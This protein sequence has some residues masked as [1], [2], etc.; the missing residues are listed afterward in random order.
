MF[1][2]KKTNKQATIVFIFHR[3]HRSTTK[4][5]GE[6]NERT[7]LLN[8]GHRSQYNCIKPTINLSYILKG[9]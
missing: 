3:F 6:F 2:S 4:E 8:N 7:N 9:S 5:K 1:L